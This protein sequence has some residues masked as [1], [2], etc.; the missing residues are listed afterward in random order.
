MIRLALLVALAPTMASADVGLYVEPSGLYGAYDDVDLPDGTHG[1]WNLR[2]GL[3][4]IFDNPQFRVH[5]G[6]TFGAIKHDFGVHPA[7]GV[8][9]GVEWKLGE[10]ALG[11]RTSAAYTFRWMY[12]GGVRV[13]RGAAF[14][15]IDG[16]AFRDEFD[17]VDPGILIGGGAVLVPTKRQT[18]IGTGVLVGGGLLVTGA[19]AVLIAIV[20]PT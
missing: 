4:A 15:A 11:V 8:E 20:P 7:A 6:A 13:R 2:A 17:S 10:L 3:G 12:T 9:G 19:L 5:A 1:W 18:A 16:V 14:L